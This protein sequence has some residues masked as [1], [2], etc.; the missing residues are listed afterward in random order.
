MFIVTR[1]ESDFIFSLYYELCVHKIAK[2]LK[3]KLYKFGFICNKNGYYK[4]VCEIHTIRVSEC[5]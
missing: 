2:I 5:C 4:D 3:M 1:Q